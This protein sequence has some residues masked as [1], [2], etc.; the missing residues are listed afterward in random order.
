MSSED[1]VCL[2]FDFDLKSRK[3]KLD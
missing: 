2:N 3:Y 1:I